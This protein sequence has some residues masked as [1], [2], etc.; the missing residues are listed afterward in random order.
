[1]NEDFVISTTK[2]DEWVANWKKQE[3]TSGPYPFF[4]HDGQVHT[5]VSFPFSSLSYLFSAV[6]V[7]TIKVRFGLREASDGRPAQFY[8]VLFGVDNTDTIITPHFISSVFT[9]GQPE[10]SPSESH[11]NLPMALM[12]RWKKQWYGKAEAKQVGVGMFTV[13]PQLDPENQGFLQGYSYPMKEMMAAVG[14]LPGAA[15]VHL[16]F[17]LHEY[18]SLPVTD[19][20]ERTSFNTFGLILYA[21]TESGQEGAG[22]KIISESGYYDFTAPCPFTC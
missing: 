14:A 22:G 4:N 11:G 7:V 1:M 19:G 16:L 5:G 13:N 21:A 8:P 10:A 12:E 18:Y 9:Y 17:G 20:D 6:G 15:S 2:Y 3:Y